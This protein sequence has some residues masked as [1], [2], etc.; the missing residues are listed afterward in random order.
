MI[1]AARGAVVLE[2][3]D[4]S[5]RFAGVVALDGVSLDLRSGEV[6]ALV[7][8][9]G[10][11]KS[12]LINVVTGVHQPDHG[13]IVYRGEPVTFARPLDAQAAGI[14]AIYQEINLVP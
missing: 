1:T 6:H 8:E 14:S 11:G 5:K 3:Q 4:V 13:R 2:V 10:A 7:G 9:N 12:T